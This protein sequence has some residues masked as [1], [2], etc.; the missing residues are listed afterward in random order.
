MLDGKCMQKISGNIDETSFLHILVL[1]GDAT[2]ENGDET[3]TVKKGDSVFLPADA[4]AYMVQGELEAL[5][6]TI[7]EEQ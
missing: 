7:P 3:I 4:G 6:T 2:I 1:D 5:F